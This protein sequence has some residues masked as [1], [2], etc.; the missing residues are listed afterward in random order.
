M[1]LLFDG[2]SPTGGPPPDIHKL[3]RSEN[4]ITS[5]TWLVFFSIFCVVKTVT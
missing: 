3:L 1:I 4:F 2:D 5:A